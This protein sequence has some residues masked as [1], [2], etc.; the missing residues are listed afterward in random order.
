MVQEAKDRS[1]ELLD[2]QAYKHR[3][4]EL[5]RQHLAVDAQIAI[6][7]AQSEGIQKEMKQLSAN[8]RQKTDILHQQKN[9]ISRIRKAD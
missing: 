5:R 1:Q 2:N 8:G 4:L 9:A 3:Q 6:L 7:K